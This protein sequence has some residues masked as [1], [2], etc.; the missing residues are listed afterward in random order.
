MSNSAPSYKYTD[1]VNR[2]WAKKLDEGNLV[3]C[4]DKK[5][6]NQIGGYNKG[7]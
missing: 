2:R 7:Q 6:K 3:C 4:F 1:R 5:R